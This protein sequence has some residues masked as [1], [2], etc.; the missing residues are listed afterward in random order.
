M[1][2]G[3]EGGAFSGSGLAAFF[4]VLSGKAGYLGRLV[5]NRHT[6]A[7]GVE[8]AERSLTSDLSPGARGGGQPS[9]DRSGRV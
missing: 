2:C 5:R 1:L 3:D 4:F 6:G 7:A 8:N 9:P